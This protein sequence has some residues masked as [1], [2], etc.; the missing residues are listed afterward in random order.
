MPPPTLGQGV[1]LTLMNARALAALVGRDRSAGQTLPA[2]EAAIRFISDRIQRWALRY[3]FF[4]RQWPSL[5]FLR[6][7]IILVF[8]SVPGTNR[9]IRTAEQGL[10]ATAIASGKAVWFRP[11]VVMPCR[12]A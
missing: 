7:A 4:T 2:W 12:A 1:G 9:G 11:E 5:W 8:W 10:K 6:P 3:D